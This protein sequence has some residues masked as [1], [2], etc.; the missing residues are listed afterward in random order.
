VNGR[1]DFVIGQLEFNIQTL[2]KDIN[3]DSINDIVRLQE[4]ID[5]E[6]ESKTWRDYV[7][8]PL[9]LCPTCMS[10]FHGVGLSLIF[11]VFHPLGAVFVSPLNGFYI[12]YSIVVSAYFNFI[13]NKFTINVAKS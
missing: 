10:S 9:L 8:L 11:V 2:R 5:R 12:I 6:K 7:G 3:A 13:L 1:R 4:R